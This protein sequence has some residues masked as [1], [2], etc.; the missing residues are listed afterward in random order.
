MTHTATMTP[1]PPQRLRALERA[2]EIR[3]A[4]AELKR[5]IAVGDVSVADVI[6]SS[7]EEAESWSVS[8]LLMSQRRWGSERCRK[9]LKRNDIYEL[10]SIGSLTN[11]QRVLLANQ[12]ESRELELVGAAKGRPAGPVSHFEARSPRG[13][14][15]EADPRPG[16]RS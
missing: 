7:P 15:G 12:L 13:S 10:K 5:R 11:R 6:L 1:G 8:E 14:H 16:A 9:F 3:L 4:R 2:N